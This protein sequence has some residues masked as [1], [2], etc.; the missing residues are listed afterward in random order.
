[1]S[2]VTFMLPA[3]PSIKIL[4]TFMVAMVMIAVEEALMVMPA[5]A[6]PMAMLLAW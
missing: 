5:L 1:M 4:A 2:E 6:W 3:V